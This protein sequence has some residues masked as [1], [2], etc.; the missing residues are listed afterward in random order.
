MNDILNNMDS[1]IYTI[2]YIPSIIYYSSTSYIVVQK[3]NPSKLS[4]V[5]LDT[6]YRTVI[7]LLV[8]VLPCVLWSQKSKQKKKK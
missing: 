7:I 3:N 8:R 4:V 1:M 6:L 5:P 2:L